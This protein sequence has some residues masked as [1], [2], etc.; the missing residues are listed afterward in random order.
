MSS[1]HLHILKTIILPESWIA[2][3]D[4]YASGFLYIKIFLHIKDQDFK[5][6]D[7]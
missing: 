2:E 6:S 7:T 4:Q 5:V 1:D 3:E